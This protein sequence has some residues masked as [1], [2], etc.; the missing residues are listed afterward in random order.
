MSAAA[1]LEPQEI[2]KNL[3]NGRQQD[4]I[5]GNVEEVLRSFWIPKHI[6][7]SHNLLNEDQIPVNA[8]AGLST[9]LRL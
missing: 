9:M 3:L 8:T 1:S 7:R 4:F 6:V 5:N 2:T